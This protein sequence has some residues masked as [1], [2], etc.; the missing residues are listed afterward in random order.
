MRC[1]SWRVVCWVVC[2]AGLACHAQAQVNLPP[3]F[4]IV[5]FAE[6]DYGIANVDLNDCGQVAYSQWQAPNGHSEIFVYDNQDIAQITRTGDRNVTTYINNS[7]Q[8][9]WGRG[10][11]RN[12]VTQLIFWDGRVESVVDENPDG[13]NGRAINNLG[14]VYWSRKISVRCPR[15]ENLF[16]WDGANT[17]QLTFDLELSNVQPSV[18]DGAEI[19][20]AKAQFCDN[21]WSAEVLVRYADGQ[22]TLPSPYTQNQATEITN[23]GFVTWLSTSRLMLW[24]GSESRL[25]LERSGR[26]ALNEW[27]RLYV[28][29]FDFEKTSWNP[30]VLDVTDEGMNMFMLRDSDYWFSDGSVNEWGEIATSWSED[31]PNSRNRGAVM[32]LR[33]IRTGDSEFDGDIDLRDHKRLVRA[34]TGPVRTEGLCEDRF[35][36]INHDGDLDLDDYAR[37][38]NAFT[39]TTP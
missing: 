27:L 3:G 22:I 16:M 10:I 5:E 4:E 9:I 25:L 36:D 33:R 26:A 7:G 28:T 30:W 19:A 23:S 39:G 12:P 24:T 37:L 38:Q 18:N 8:L 32:Y 31:P 15:Q 20:W 2:V 21:P 6:N 14:H 17:T 35:L 34:M 29:I 1:R 11:D 13:F